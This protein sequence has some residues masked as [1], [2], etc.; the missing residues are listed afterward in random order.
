MESENPENEIIITEE[1]ELDDETKKLLAKIPKSQLKKLIQPYKPTLSDKQKERNEKLVALNKAKWEKLRQE[2]KKYEEDQ[3]KILSK[4]VKIKPKRDYKRKPV[5]YVSEES[6]EDEQD[7]EEYIKYKKWKDNQKKVIKKPDKNNSD[8]DE[9][10]QKTKPKIE[11][12]T[13][14]L[15]TVN[16][17]DNALKSLSV[18][19]PYF[20]AMNRKR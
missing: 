14:I 3:L 2:R 9:Y 4:Q 10:I 1:T 18:N 16:K 17:L 11:K 12:A 7:M 20:E 19:N 13:E 15:N 8:D 6:E 5:V